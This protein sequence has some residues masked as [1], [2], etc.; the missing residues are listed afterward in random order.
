MT[1]KFKNYNQGY[2][3][4]SLALDESAKAELINDGLDFVYVDRNAN[5]ICLFPTDSVLSSDFN[6]LDNIVYYNNY[7]VFELWN[8]GMF[9]RKYDDSSN[10]NYFFI[11]GKCNSNC[12]MC[13]SS[14]NSR[15]TSQPAN[16]Q[17]LLA[18][19]KH[20]P[21]DVSHLT[22]TG[23]EPFLMGDEIFV[24][25]QY[26]KARF[27]DTEFLFLTNGRIFALEKY[28]D[29]FVKTAP[30]KSIVAVP[31]H[32]SCEQ[33]HDAITRSKG[34]FRQTLFGLKKLK[35]AGIPIEIRLVVSKMNVCDFENLAQ[36]IVEQLN[37]VEYV[38][39]IAMEMTGTARVNHDQVWLPYTQAFAEIKS[40]TSKLIKN[41]I[42]VKLYN[43][44]LCTVEKSFWTLCEQSISANKVR[45]IEKCDK[46]KYRSACC[47]VFAGTL[48]LERDDLKPI[49]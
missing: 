22:I 8:N 9:V 47:G 10:D 32:G 34:S 30:E 3:I 36:L 33:I 20:I 26:L 42:D 40:A 13:P 15:R 11:S 29:S 35:Q 7:D 25:L 4:V 16:L 24:F 6:D 45:F 21:S 2:R 17:T 48:Q 23:G 12:I 43:F 41:G 18:L 44:P 27:C 37:G 14:E 39:I 38:S 49:I 28:V 46:C 1:I 19:A 31:I 5:A